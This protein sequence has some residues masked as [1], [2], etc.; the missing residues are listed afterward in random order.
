MDPFDK[1]QPPAA[2]GLC[3]FASHMLV[4]TCA[5]ASLAGAGTLWTVGMLVAAFACFAAECLLWMRWAQ[6]R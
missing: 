1:P 3:G 2:V 5:L 6:R 4:V